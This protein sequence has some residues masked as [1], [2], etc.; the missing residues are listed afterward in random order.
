MQKKKLTLKKKTISANGTQ[1]HVHEFF[2]TLIQAPL[3]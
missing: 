2:A 1:R 3:I